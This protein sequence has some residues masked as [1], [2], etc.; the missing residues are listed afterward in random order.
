MVQYSETSPEKEEANS[1]QGMNRNIG[2]G[3]INIY[4]ASGI[5]FVIKTVFQGH[6]Y[7]F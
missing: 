1:L 6:T 5:D 2:N 7:C 4:E 3:F